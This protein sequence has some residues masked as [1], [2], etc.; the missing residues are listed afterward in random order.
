MK[1]IGGLLLVLF[2]SDVY[3]Q[4]KVIKIEPYA[5]INMTRLLKREINEFYGNLTENF[6]VHPQLGG[7][8]GVLFSVN[9]VALSPLIGL[10]FSRNTCYATMTKYEGNY[11]INSGKRYDVY[12]MRW[13]LIRTDFLFMLQIALGPEHDIRL[14]GGVML[15]SNLSNFSQQRY[16][17]IDNTVSPATSTH[18]DKGVRI[19]NTNTFLCGG[20]Q[21]PVP[22]TNFSIYALWRICPGQ[23]NYNYRLTES[24]MQLSVCYNLSN[25]KQSAPQSPAR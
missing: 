13:D 19:S 24:G 11:Y 4:N 20:V 12:Y 1:L 23:I 14:Q 9:N 17:V 7:Q 15:T 21:L 6:K 16:W 5:G 22:E 3:A 8:A 18:V 2:I 10:Q 25:R